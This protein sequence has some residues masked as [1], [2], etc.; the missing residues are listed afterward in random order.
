MAAIVV[1]SGGNNGEIWHDITD[2]LIWSNTKQA[3][4]FPAGASPIKSYNIINTV[5]FR[6]VRWTKLQVQ[7]GEVYRVTSWYTNYNRDF[8][9]EETYYTIDEHGT[10]TG[11]YPGNTAFVYAVRTNELDDTSADIAFAYT[12]QDMDNHWKYMTERFTI[13]EIPSGHSLWLYNF[14]R[15]KKYFNDFRLEKLVQ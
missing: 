11:T 8:A 3:L 12:M 6:D 15:G 1:G 5:G 4:V 10:Q 2:Q 13:P 9:T 14:G 7:K